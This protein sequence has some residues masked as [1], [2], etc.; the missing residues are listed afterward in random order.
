MILAAGTTVVIIYSSRHSRLT[1][2]WA[3]AEKLRFEA[4]TTRRI[5]DAKISA[6]ASFRF[7]DDHQGQWPTSFAQLN[8]ERPESRLSDSDW[9]FVSGGNRASFTNLAQTILFRE[10]EARRS[11]DGAFV[12]VY[13]FADYSIQV[14][15][16]PHDDFATLEKE[17]GYLIQPTTN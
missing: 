12:K 7:A 16:S 11:P 2:Q 17:R 10:R 4:E 14:L 5:N 9:E 13:A 15:T 3:L 8:A 6:V 1:S